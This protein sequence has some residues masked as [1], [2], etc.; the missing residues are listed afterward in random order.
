MTGVSTSPALVRAA[1]GS[2]VTQVD[3]AAV[4]ALGTFDA[5]SLG[6]AT[7]GAVAERLALR[8]GTAAMCDERDARL[9]GRAP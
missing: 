7:P 2:P 1:R 4:R 8:L 3:A 9:D 5:I 6:D